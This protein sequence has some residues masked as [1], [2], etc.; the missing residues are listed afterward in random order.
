[1][2]RLLL[3][4]ARALLLL[5]VGFVVGVAAVAVHARAWGLVLAAVATLAGLVALPPGFSSR[6]AYAAGWVIP[7]GLAMIPRPEGDYLIASDPTG[8]ALL[9]VGMVLLIAAL[10]TLP[11][12]RGKRRP[13]R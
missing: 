11:G 6:V 3:R 13:G 9:G 10:A 2:S 7:L 12:G 5:V 1:M 4:L 8:Y